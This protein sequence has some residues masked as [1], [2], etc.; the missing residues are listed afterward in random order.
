MRKLIGAA[1]VLAFALI[2][3]GPA[4]SRQ[5]KR[6]PCTGT[7]ESGE[8][9]EKC[10]KLLDKKDIKDGKCSADQTAVIKVQVCNKK[11]FVCGCGKGGCCS[12]DKD[13]AGSCKCGK[14]LKPEENKM[15][16]QYACK[17]C[18]AM[19]PLKDKVMHTAECKK[20][21]VIA[22]CGH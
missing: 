21:D 6:P 16:V 22:N 11:H 10:A 14:P 20:K 5:E 17:G 15:V 4:L 13:K 8:Y 2:V 12:D 9:C 19:S 7:K 1:S 3:A 18:G